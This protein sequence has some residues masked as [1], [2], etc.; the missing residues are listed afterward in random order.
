MLNVGAYCRVSTDSEEQSLSL[1][2]QKQYFR[3]KINENPNWKLK[4][5]YYDEGVTGTSTEHREGFNRMIIDALN[6][7]LDLI[8]TK[9]VS[10]FS[11]N[12]VDTLSY[13]NDLKECG[14]A[15][16]FLTDNINSLDKDIEL[17]LTLM[18]S[19]AQE[20]SRKTSERVKWGQKRRMEQGVVFGRDLLGYTVKKGK[21]YINE[22]E[23]E[24]VRLIFHK[25]LNEEKG[26]HVIARELREAGIKPK[27]VKEWSNTVI[28]RVLRNEK[29]V[30][31]LCQKKTY[32]PN[33][34][35]HKKKY[36]IGAEEMVYLK[37]HHEPIIDR[38]TWDRTQEELARRSLSAEQKAK[39][40]NRYWCSGKLVCGECGR[41]MVSHIRKRKNGT[42]NKTW[43]CYESV[44]N[45]KRKIDRFGDEIGCDNGSVSDRTLLSAVAYCLK[46]IQTNFTDLKQELLDEIKTVQSFRPKDNTETLYKK[47]ESLQKK[48]TKA[49]NLLLDEIITEHELKEQKKHIDNEISALQD[50]IDAFINYESEIKKKTKTIE[51]YIA[52]IDSIMS[53]DTEQTE[54]YGS[55]TEK[56]VIN[57][58]D[59]LIV[60]FKGLPFGISLS[61]KTSGKGDKYKSEFTYLGAVEISE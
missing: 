58:N 54:I 60:Y 16:V 23:A 53:Y 28:L 15:V 21:L 27:R 51:E 29:Y 55:V 43:S 46:F 57:K 59:T 14:V 30:G 49:I 4:E 50:K 19:I 33:Y 8:V 40:S 5:V 12:T 13:I 26:T 6:G 20:E 39:H 11:R 45:G 35:T 34:L 10:R 56:I 22:V 52:E 47:I 42:D 7:E 25:F 32:T 2:S 48:K 24:T 44:K 31:D 1:E 38:E 41:R 9:E 3:E 36:N 61:Y 18:A 37:D 17:R